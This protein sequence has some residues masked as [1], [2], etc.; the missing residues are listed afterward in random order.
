MYMNIGITTTGD[1][2]AATSWLKRAAKANPQNALK[3]L[4]SQG[5]SRLASATPK[6]TGQTAAGW[7]CKVKKTSTG[8]DIEWYN[9]AH[10]GTGVNVAKILQLGHGTGTGG[11]VPGRDYINPA[12]KPIF[13]DAG[14]K[15]VRELIK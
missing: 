5:V 14:D 15:L 8:W 12:L 6:D 3:A 13:D 9:T 10:A 4:G 7:A 11:Y 1:F 2:S